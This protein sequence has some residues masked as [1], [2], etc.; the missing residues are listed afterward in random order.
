MDDE[1][2]RNMIMAGAFI[3]L[4]IVLALWQV[5]RTLSRGGMDGPGL[6]KLASSIFIL[7]IMMYVGYTALSL[8]T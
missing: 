4:M 8:W 2:N 7:G 6:V 1:M 5:M 3:A